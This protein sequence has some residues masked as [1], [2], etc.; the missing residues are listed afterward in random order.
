MKRNITDFFI[1]W[2]S[3]PRRKP[4][5]VRGAR[6][7]GKSYSITHF[8]KTHFD[9]ELHIVNLEK[10]LNWHK[11]F[12]EDLDAVRI[13]HE[14][15][16]LL[17]ARIE[18]GRDLLFFDEIQACPSA[19]TALR[20]FFEQ[21]PELHVIAAGSLLE[22]ALQN[23]SFPVGRVQLVNMYPM[24]FAEYLTALGK[25]KLSQL[26]EEGPANLSET[27][28]KRLRKEVKQYFFIGG[29]PECV[30]TFSETS[31][32][33][34]VFEVQGDLMNT[35]R[36]DFSKYTPSVNKQCL[37]DVLFSISQHIGQQIKYSQLSNNFTN[38]TIKKAFDLL[39]T[40]R[41]IHKVRSTPSV[42]LPMS[43]S[44]SEKKFK[45]IFLDI[46]LLGYLSGLS[47]N[48]EFSKDHLLSIY[49]GALA[50]Q[51]V[52]QELLANGQQELYYWARSTKSS[53]AE[54]DYLINHHDS[55]IPLEVKS[56]S[57]GRLKS[58][59][60]LLKQYAHVTQAYVLSDREMGQIPDQKLTF[61]PLY[62][63]SS[64]A[65]R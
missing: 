47:I 43:L 59:H 1:K 46:G 63:A 41:I 49:R 51:F 62:Y 45:A 6:Q 23:I 33:K 40:A 32:I 53:T 13:L 56:G 17:N 64:L 30:R 61:I 48:T 7:V 22:F 3:H 4:L 16:I 37:N 54:V 28:H 12:E 34:D 44:A 11:I 19:I 10:Q 50:E 25:E 58:L 21:L 60:L 31:K 18:P 9:G 2:K 5:L 26:I 20:Y 15:E 38:P 36:Q 52:G 57:S 35:F 42:G 39:R 55:V 14:L 65:N 8:G 29:M 24:T 27:L